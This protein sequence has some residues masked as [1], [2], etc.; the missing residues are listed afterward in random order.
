MLVAGVALMAA[1]MLSVQSALGSGIARRDAVRVEE[2]HQQDAMMF[3]QDAVARGKQG[4]A[5]AF[6]T[7]A[8]AALQHALEAGKGPHVEA[9][10]TELKHAIEQAKA[11]HADVATAHAKQAIIHFS[12][13]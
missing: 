3:A 2:Q 7:S 6:L 13:K 11:G 4:Q 10:V 9:A 1:T 12:A 8:E 5:N